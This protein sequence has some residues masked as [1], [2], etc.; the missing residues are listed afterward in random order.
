MALFGSP[1][2]ASDGAFSFPGM[3]LGLL[4]VAALL[5]AT[6]A[7]SRLFLPRG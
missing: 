2:S 3:R 1:L 7:L 6:A 4:T 5:L